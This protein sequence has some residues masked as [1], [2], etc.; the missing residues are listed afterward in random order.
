MKLE[1]ERQMLNYGIRSAKE[2]RFH[3]KGCELHSLSFDPGQE[4]SC[5]DVKLT[6]KNVTHY[7]PKVSKKRRIGSL[8]PHGRI[9]HNFLV[10][11]K[12]KA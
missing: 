11:S 1:P 4:D 2:G 3:P 7:C 8:P 12:E 6:C 10:S 9:C 5:N